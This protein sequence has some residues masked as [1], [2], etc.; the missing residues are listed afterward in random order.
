MAVMAP[1]TPLVALARALDAGS[2]GAG[3]FNATEIA[4]VKAGNALFMMSV[5]LVFAIQEFGQSAACMRIADHN[6]YGT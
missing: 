4:F 3:S 5:G 2:S 1:L 6:T